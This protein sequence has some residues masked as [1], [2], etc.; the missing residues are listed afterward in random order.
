MK[1]ANVKRYIEEE[2]GDSVELDDELMKL[3]ESEL[4]KCICDFQ[5]LFGIEE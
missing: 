1:L 3:E 2:L 4:K 5:K